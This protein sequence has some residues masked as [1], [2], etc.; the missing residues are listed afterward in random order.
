M[1]IPMLKPI[2]HTV[3]RVLAGLL[4]AQHGAQKLFGL[5]GGFGGTPGAKAPLMGMMG[6]AGVIEFGGGLL[7]AIGFFTRPVAAL[8][9]AEMAF[10]YFTVH[11][12]QGFWPIQNQGELAMLYG[13]TWVYFATHGAG[14]FSAD[15]M[16]K[17]A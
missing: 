9:A 10:A 14:Q 16:M 4:F 2:A 5:L 17:K 8:A 1:N 7:I 11:L 13:A 15:G 3:F 6:L 12:P